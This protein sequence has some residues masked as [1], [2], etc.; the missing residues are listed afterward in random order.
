M[1]CYGIYKN[2]RMK[3]KKLCIKRDKCYKKNMLT[4]CKI[5]KWVERY[6]NEDFNT[7]VKNFKFTSIIKHDNKFSFYH[8]PKLTLNN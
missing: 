5:N 2:N 3:G 6:V 7:R 8:R 4:M 1:P